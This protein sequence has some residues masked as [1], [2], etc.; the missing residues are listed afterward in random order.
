[1]SELSLLACGT[2]T[3][4]LK[5]K[6]SRLSQIID[7]TFDRYELTAASLTN[8]EV[9]ICLRKLNFPVR[10]SYLLPIFKDQISSWKSFQRNL[11]LDENYILKDS[12]S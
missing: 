8:H 4:L 2:E 1:M 9:D 6:I 7:G 3:G 10:I 5:T 11:F 12:R